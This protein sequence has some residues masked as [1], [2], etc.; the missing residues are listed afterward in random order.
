M[1]F[2]C[3]VVFLPEIETTIHLIVIICRFVEVSSHGPAVTLLL[4]NS[5]D[6]KTYSID[7]VPAIKDNSWPEDAIEWITRPRRG[8][9]KGSLLIQSGQRG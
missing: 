6:G 5:S 7:L 9:R 2:A 3:S 4:T 1:H 8:T